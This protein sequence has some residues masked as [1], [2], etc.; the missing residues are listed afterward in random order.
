M[1][2]ILNAYLIQGFL[3]ELERIKTAEKL[4]KETDGFFINSLFNLD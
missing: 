1:T 3:D 4:K 2:K